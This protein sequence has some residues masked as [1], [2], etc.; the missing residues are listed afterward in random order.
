MSDIW[1]D[2]TDD[3]RYSG[4]LD[5]CVARAGKGDKIYVMTDNSN[6]IESQF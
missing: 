2:C 4:K 6:L 5:R 1:F 3:F